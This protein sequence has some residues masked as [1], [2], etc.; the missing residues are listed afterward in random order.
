MVNRGNSL[1]ITTEIQRLGC[2]HYDRCTRMCEWERTKKF[3]G[4]KQQTKQSNK[5][6]KVYLYKQMSDAQ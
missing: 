6:N 1:L 2:A 4:Y 3:E 5:F